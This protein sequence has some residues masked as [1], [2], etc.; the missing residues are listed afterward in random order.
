M[1]ASVVTSRNPAPVL[2][3][4]EHALDAV[5]LLVSVGVVVDVLLAIFTTRDARLYAPFGEGLAEPIAVITAIGDQDIR[6]WQG[7]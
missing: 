2:E 5:A 3:A 6:L 4:S 1:S 7:R